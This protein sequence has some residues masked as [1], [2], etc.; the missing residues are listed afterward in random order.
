LTIE[1]K[2]GYNYIMTAFAGETIAQIGQFPITNTLLDTIIV[3]G[4]IIGGVFSLKNVKMVPNM[5]QNVAEIAIDGFYNLTE[6]ISPKH[7]DK[8]FPYFMS[9]FVFILVANWSGL[10]PG[11]GGTIFVKHG[12]ESIPL[13]RAATSDINTTLALALISAVATHVMSIAVVGIKD[14]ALRYLSI[15]PLYLFIGVLE[16]ISE[17]TKVISLSFRLFGNIFAG[18]VL[19]GTISNMFAFLLPLPFLTLEIIVGLVQS[20]VFSML[21]MAFMAILTTPHHAEEEAH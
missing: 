11:F 7:V 19:I 13:L 6:S 2:T 4:L 8:I 15:N 3:D 12:E 18:E 17:F 10:I 1:A 20:L 21:T 16:I 14:Y 9:F 5:F